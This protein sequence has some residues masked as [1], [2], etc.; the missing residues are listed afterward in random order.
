[1]SIYAV[2]WGA[3]LIGLVEARRR[4]VRSLQKWG[5]RRQ[6]A[7]AADEIGRREFIRGGLLAIATLWLGAMAFGFEG[8]ESAVADP[9]L[10]SPPRSSAPT[11]SES[12]SGITHPIG[13]PI[14]QLDKVPIGGA[15]GFDDPAQGPSVLVRLGRDRVAAFSRTCTHAGCLVDY[16]QAAGLLVCPCHGAEFDPAHGAEV[17]AGPAPTP[18]PEVPVVI[19]RSTGRVVATS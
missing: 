5:T 7:A 14:A 11:P 18:L 8:R 9:P 12:S 1:D 6:R 2:A 16:D 4:A 13:T 17:V 10:A 15:V 3:Y 19:D